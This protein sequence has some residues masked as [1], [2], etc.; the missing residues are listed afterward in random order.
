MP[1]GP[2]IRR[3]LMRCQQEKQNGNP[4]VTVFV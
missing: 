3:A 4:K 1:E 2:E